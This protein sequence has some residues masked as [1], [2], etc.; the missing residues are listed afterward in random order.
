[1]LVLL[2]LTGSVGA[3]RPLEGLVENFQTQK[4]RRLGTSSNLACLEDT[5]S[6]SHESVQVSRGSLA[7]RTGRITKSSRS[8]FIQIARVILRQPISLLFDPS[9]K[10]LPHARPL[11]KSSMFGELAI[12]NRDRNS[13]RL[14][15]TRIPRLM[16]HLA[17]ISRISRD[18]QSILASFDGD[19]LSSFRDRYDGFAGE[20][21]DIPKS[22]NQCQLVPR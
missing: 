22:G 19:R 11:L 21:S 7:R 3:C 9:P 16:T 18:D 12:L 17:H 6:R 2:R 1:M 15:P 13:S 8:H 20:E 5:H 10:N 4:L 14:L